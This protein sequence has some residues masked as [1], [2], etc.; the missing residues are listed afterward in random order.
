M[1][2]REE[3]KLGESIAQ[4]GWRWGY[5]SGTSDTPAKQQKLAPALP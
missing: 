1:T 5:T 4:G 3:S 2:E